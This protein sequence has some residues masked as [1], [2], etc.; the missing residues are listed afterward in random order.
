MSHLKDGPRINLVP[1]WVQIVGG[2]ALG[3][4]VAQ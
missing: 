3:A 1:A 4:F 2:F